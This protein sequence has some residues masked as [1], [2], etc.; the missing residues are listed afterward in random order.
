MKPKKEATVKLNRTAVAE[1][2]AI[3]EPVAFDANHNVV[4]NH[5]SNAAQDGNIIGSVLELKKGKKGKCGSKK[6][7]RC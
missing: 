1:P 5:A 7:R 4:E 3:S 2:M 6:R